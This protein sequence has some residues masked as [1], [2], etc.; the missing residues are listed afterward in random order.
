M[1][2]HSQMSCQLV[3][4]RVGEALVRRLAG[5]REL[6][7]VE[8]LQGEQVLQ[9]CQSGKLKTDQFLESGQVS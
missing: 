5:E 8:T 4:F 6:S 7:K 2:M 3:D 9:Q 1:D